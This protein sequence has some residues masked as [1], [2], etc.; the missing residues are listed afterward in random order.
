VNF[1]A[2]NQAGCASFHQNAIV[3]LVAEGLPP[4]DSRNPNQARDRTTEMAGLAR[5]S[6]SQT[7]SDA[8]MS[9]PISGAE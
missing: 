1:G 9:A 6:S 2:S 3:G 8:S 7:F 5:D 4:L